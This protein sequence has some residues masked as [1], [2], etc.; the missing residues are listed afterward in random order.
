MEIKLFK[1]NKMPKDMPKEVQEYLANRGRGQVRGRGR[2]RGY[3]ASSYVVN[4]PVA[5]T[6]LV[7]VGNKQR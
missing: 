4:G 3:R 7:R 5:L 2:G 6:K 1:M